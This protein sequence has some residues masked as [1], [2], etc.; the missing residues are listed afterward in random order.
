MNNRVILLLLAGLEKTVK[1]KIL[2]LKSN[3]KNWF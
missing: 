2:L 3:I 1:K